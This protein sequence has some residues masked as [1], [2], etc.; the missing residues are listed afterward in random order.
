MF[1]VEFRVFCFLGCLSISIP[2]LFPR[3]SGWNFCCVLS[4]RLSVFCFFYSLVRP[5]FSL[6][7]IPLP[8]HRYIAF[9]KMAVE[10]EISRRADKLQSENT[11]AGKPER[12]HASSEQHQNGQKLLGRVST[13]HINTKFDVVERCLSLP[14]N[15]PCS[16]NSK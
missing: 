13:L 11:L 7:W 1:S 16:T 12:A 5:V 6:L 10:I 4:C 2:C 9:L 15:V 14:E 8:L 3:L